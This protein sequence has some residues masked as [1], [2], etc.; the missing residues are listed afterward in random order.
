MTR[1]TG[2]SMYMIALALGSDVWGGMAVDV[3]VCDN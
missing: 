2:T 1:P 3:G